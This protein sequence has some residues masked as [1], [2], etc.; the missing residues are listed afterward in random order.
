MGKILLGLAMLAVLGW[1][2]WRYEHERALE[3]RLGRVASALAGRPVRVRCESSAGAMIDVGAELGTVQFDAAGHPADSTDLK[4]DVCVWLSSL[5]H[6]PSGR[7]RAR[8]R[9]AD[10]R[11]GAPRRLQGRVGGAVPRA[12]ADG[13]GGAAARRE[14][15]A[16]APLDGDLRARTPSMPPEYYDPTCPAF[17]AQTTIPSPQ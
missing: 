4:H 1:G 7:G 13:L 5:Q 17:R 12:P 16:G 3:H 9:G 8:R 11:V 15:R 14:R 2:G 6:R 10:A